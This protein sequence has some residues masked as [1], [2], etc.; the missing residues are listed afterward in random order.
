MSHEVSGK[1]LLPENA[2]RPLKPGEEYVPI[3]PANQ[4]PAEVTPWS[5]TMGILMVILFSAACVYVAL[6][7]GSGIEAAIPI[8]VAAIFFGRF[9]KPNST[10]LENVIVQSIGQASG[11]VAAGAAFTIPALYIN[12]VDVSWWHIFLACFLGGSL[13]IVLIIPLRKHFVKDRHGELPFPEG[14]ATTEILVSGQS[15]GAGGGKILMASFAL[16]AAYDFVVEAFQAWNPALTTKTLLKGA[17]EW[18]YNFRIEIKMNA[19]AM[20]FG[21]GYIIGLKYAAIIMAGSVLAY[22][23]MV[24]LVYQFLAPLGTMQFLGDTLNVGAMSASDIFA[25]FIKPIGIGAIATAGILGLIRMGKIIIS[26]VSLGFKGIGQK[27]GADDSVPRTQKDLSPSKVLLIQGVVTLLLGILFFVVCL[28]FYSLT[29]SLVYALVGMLISFFLCFL[30]T[31]VAAEAI[32]IVGTNPVSGMTLV[33]VVLASLVM[34]GIGLSGSAGTF[35]VLIVGCAVCT[36]LSTSGALI[37]DF[38]IGYWIGSTPHSQQRWKFLGVAIASLVVAFVIPLMDSS[39]HFLVEKDQTVK[40]VPETREALT[41]AGNSLAT[42]SKVWP[43]AEEQ[44]RSA[45]PD[46]A[47]A[48]E[49]FKNAGNSLDKAAMNLSAAA[50]T[51]P[52]KSAEPAAP[53]GEV[54][55]GMLAAGQQ[56]IAAGQALTGI[57]NSLKTDQKLDSAGQPIKQLRSNSEVLPAPQ[58]NMIAEVVKGLMSNKQ[59]PYLLYGLGVL[60]ALLLFMA[61][62]PALAFALGMY[63]PIS[64]NMT[65]LVGGFVAWLIGRSGKT[66]EEGERRANQGTLIASGM[67]AGAALFGILTA[68]MRLEWLDYPIRFLAIGSKMSVEETEGVRNLV[69]QPYPWFQGFTGQAISLVAFLLL[70]LATY[71]LARWGSAL[72]RKDEEASR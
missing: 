29:M 64:L 23:V 14:T 53:N 11:V 40:A 34:A 52:G 46:L 10:L 38:K 5:L 48:A 17:G 55:T 66:K 21:L 44:I 9:K 30:F 26:S 58:A 65:V 56:L 31:P 69:E 36:A 35:V 70:I 22:M 12:Q 62:V 32:A 39:Y 7:A 45:H 19:I 18:F 49:Q 28:P 25:T 50:A 68:V 27:A 20:L 6:R 16:G 3:V 8:A 41:Q 51:I 43:Q 24:P 60:I 2:Y 59:Q 61:G 37:S 13:G 63:L 57:S 54:P 71:G 67:M 1:R 15:S 72:S 33:T 42:A 47:L 4:H